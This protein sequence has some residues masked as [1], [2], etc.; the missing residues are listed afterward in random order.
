MDLIRICARNSSPKEIMIV[1]QEAI[2]NLQSSLDEDESSDPELVQR[3]IGIVVLSSSG[4]FLV[5]SF[6]EILLIK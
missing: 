3:T 1:V 2:E 6:K 5:C 4:F